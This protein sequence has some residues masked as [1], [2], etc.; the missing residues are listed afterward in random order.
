MS[1]TI[2]LVGS[3]EWLPVMQDV[4][5]ELLLNR[6]PVYVQLS[7]AAGQE[8]KSRIEHWQNLGINQ[9]KALNV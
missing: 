5:K 3:G 1:G 2:A 9:A 8:S 6:P 4:E 7:T